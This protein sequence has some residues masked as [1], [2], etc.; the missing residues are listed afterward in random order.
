MATLLISPFQGG[1]LREM[2]RWLFCDAGLNFFYLSLLFIYNWKNFITKALKPQK[3]EPSK[4]KLKLY[5]L[6]SNVSQIQYLKWWIYSDG[7]LINDLFTV[8][9]SKK[10]WVTRELRLS[11]WYCAGVCGIC[12]GLILKWVCYF[13]S[14]AVCIIIFFQ[15]QGCPKV[16][17]A[18]KKTN[19]KSVLRYQ[20]IRSRINSNVHLKGLLSIFFQL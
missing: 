8:D 19:E 6:C 16:A 18:S 17:D 3:T 1:W 7:Q 12:R 9:L 13:L 5:Q 2:A 10:I 20:I 4:T 11:A 14:K 15:F